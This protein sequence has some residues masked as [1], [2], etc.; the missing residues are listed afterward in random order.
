MIDSKNQDW[1]NKLWTHMA[2]SSIKSNEYFDNSIRLLT[3]ITASG[4]WWLP[5]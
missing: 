5:E 2:S 1:L 4:N 3:M